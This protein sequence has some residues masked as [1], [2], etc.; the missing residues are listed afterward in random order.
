MSA[1]MAF[2]A[3][4]DPEVLHLIDLPEPHAG[5]G[6]I[7]V[8]MRAAGVQPFDCAFRRG[9][10]QGFKAAQFPQVLGNDFAGIVDETGDGVTTLT[11]GDHVLGFCTLA[12]HAELIVVPVDQVVARPPSLPWEVAGGLSASGETA[13]NALRDLGVNKGDTPGPCCCRRGGNRRRPAGA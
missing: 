3:Y 12:A 7:R 11:K 4:G 5:P 6:E 8:R 1:A 10:L 9:A 13:Y 2:S